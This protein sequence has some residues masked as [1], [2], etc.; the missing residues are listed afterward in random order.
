MAF[1]FGQ[2]VVSI[3]QVGGDHEPKYFGCKTFTNDVTSVLKVGEGMIAPGKFGVKFFL[4]LSNREQRIS[5]EQL[6]ITIIQSSDNNYTFDFAKMQEIFENNPNAGISK[7]LSNY[8][9][10]VLRRAQ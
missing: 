3:V 9:G 10:S 6:Q 8:F 2:K 4:A 7:S 5:V 1:I